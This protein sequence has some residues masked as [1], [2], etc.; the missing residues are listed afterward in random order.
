MPSQCVGMT[1]LIDSGTSYS[2]KTQIACI[3]LFYVLCHVGTLLV[4]SVMISQTPKCNAYGK[5]EFE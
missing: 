5:Q 3:T 1:Y 4:L 2:H